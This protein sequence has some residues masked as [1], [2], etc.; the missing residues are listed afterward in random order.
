MLSPFEEVRMRIIGSGCALAG[1]LAL[2]LGATGAGAAQAQGAPPIRIAVETDMSGVLSAL[3]GPTSLRAVQMAVDDAGGSVLGRKIEVVAIDHRNNAG[4]GAA[5]AREFW[6]Q[7]GDLIVDL[8][9]SGVAIAVETVGRELHKLALVTGG[10]SSDISSAASTP[11]STTPTAT[12][13]RTRPAPTS[14]RNRA[15]S[16]GTSSTPT[17]PSVTRC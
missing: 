14:P 15:A 7:G 10:Y 16:A 12:R 3:S 4:E 5:K 1:A 11:T 2:A 9:N 6:A 17:T 8:T 13:S